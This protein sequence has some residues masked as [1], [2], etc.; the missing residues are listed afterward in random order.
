MIYKTYQDLRR[1]VEQSLDLEEELYI[2]P[3]EML[4]YANE[5]I[6]EAEAEIQNI[7][8][9]YL[10]TKAPL[11]FVPN[12]AV[13]AYPSNI[14]A[15][16]I[17]GI[18]YQ[19]GADRYEVRRIRRYHQ[20]SRIA[21]AEYLQDTSDF[22]RWDQRNDSPTSGAKIFLVP[23]PQETSGTA[24]SNLTIASPG[25]FTTAAPH[26]LLVGTE[27]FLDTNGTL[28]TG[29]TPQ[30]IYIVNTTPST[31]TFTVT[32]TPGGRDINTSGTQ[33]GTHSFEAAPF[34]MT[35][36]FIRCL[37]RMTQDTDVCDIPQF[38]GFIIKHMRKSCL[39]K[40][41]SNPLLQEAKLELEQSRSQMVGTLAEMT[42]DDDNTH[43]Q[44]F[45]HYVEHS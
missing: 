3:S 34:R 25:V 20:A 37:N 23:T 15:Q 36:W 14:Y 41:P 42:E 7:H 22:Y 32:E 35:V 19:N 39:M 2:A 40:E 45:S 5:A 13:Y 17:R 10:K 12:R 27:I 9:N 24:I 43:E 16:K 38:Y 44:D 8:E 30:R 31:T 33:T 11:W 21:D 18:H 1:E 28:P 29:L 6:E 26:G 4:R